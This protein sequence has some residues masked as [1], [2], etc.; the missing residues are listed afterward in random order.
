MACPRPA[1]ARPGGP[2][3]RRPTIRILT[4]DT[5]A[6]HSYQL[7]A[8]AIAAVLPVLAPP[9]SDELLSRRLLGTAQ[10]TADGWAVTT[11]H[12]ETTTYTDGAAA[13]AAI[14]DL[15]LHPR[16]H[17]AR[18]ET[19]AP[20]TDNEPGTEPYGWVTNA[21]FD[22]K[23]REVI[24]RGPASLLLSVPSI[25]EAVSAHYHHQV[26]EELGDPDTGPA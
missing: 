13:L 26:L 24:D 16:S 18:R 12:T 14:A 23:L 5:T 19:M 7:P 22:D 8:E 21:V 10:R 6:I 15:H 3:R 9:T 20:A 25:Y 11:I 4:D 17:E 2:G 1:A